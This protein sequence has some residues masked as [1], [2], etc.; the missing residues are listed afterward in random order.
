MSRRACD[1]SPT[2]NLVKVGSSCGPQGAEFRGGEGGRQAVA[3]LHK[4]G[5]AREKNLFVDSLP[6]PTQSKSRR[7]QGGCHCKDY[8]TQLR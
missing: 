8:I 7:F 2:R 6:A 1:A 5:T 3:S 4:A